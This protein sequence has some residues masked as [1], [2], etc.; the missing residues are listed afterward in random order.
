M[1]KSRTNASI[2]NSTVASSAQ[3]INLIA[4]F[5]V[6][7][8]FI[9]TLGGQYLGLNG[10]F[11]NILN[12]LSFTELGI[13]AA[14]TFSLYKPLAENNEDQVAALMALYG[15]IYHAIAAIIFVLG[16][17]LVPFLHILIHG[18]IEALGNIHIAFC[19]FLLNSVCSYLGGYKRSIFF[20]DQS[21]YLNSLNLLI[22]QL[23]TQLLQGIFLVL[24]PN[25]YVYLIIQ[26]LLTIS[27]N[28]QISRIANK[29][30]PFLKTKSRLKVDKTTITY[31]KKNV[32]GMI[33]SK[34]GGVIVF[35]TD[36]LILSAFLGL[37]S[38]AKYSNYTMILTGVTSILNQGVSAVT[39]SIGNLKAVG[40]ISKQRKVFYQ[41]SQ[42]NG[43]L[44]IAI[45]TALIS[46]YS[47][48][49]N[50][51][52]GDK[53]ILSP[54]VTWLIVINFFFGQLR[55]ANI[56][57]TNAYGL[58]W[59]QR[60]KPIFEAGVNLALSLCLVKYAHMGIAG[61]LIGTISS[62]LLV[63]SWWEPLVLLKHGIKSNFLEYARF[64]FLQLISGTIL[65]TTAQA[66]SSVLFTISHNLIL[67]FLLTIFLMILNL[68]V[69]EKIIISFGYPKEIQVLSVV[70]IL[71][72]KIR[73]FF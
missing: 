49:I 70:N 43:V 18:N 56:N 63:N 42:I 12:V 33:S 11:V 10:L 48:F 59:E 14:I 66:I 38:V 55:Q 37:I 20:A 31:L 62:N 6:R 22:F 25:Y 13:G 44:N 17:A 64:Y 72:R 71:V 29:K 40:N 45:S 7:S 57:F 16:M 50:F 28:I 53:Y 51:W 69:F 65:I 67:N 73:N 26:I 5:V 36:N 23:T 3:L 46:F 54:L 60:Y 4:S 41:Y 68:I 61:V 34:L 8:L 27:S 47:P 58:Y 2:I 52:I 39:S 19:L 1:N 21:G 35:G 9:Q 30:Y 15:K 32:T 24:Y